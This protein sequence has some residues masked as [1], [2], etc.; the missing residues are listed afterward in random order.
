MF[1]IPF[2]ACIYHVVFLIVLSPLECPI[3]ESKAFEKFCYYDSHHN[4]FLSMK[5]FHNASQNLM[6]IFLIEKN[7]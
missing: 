5:S 6:M 4:T 3:P 1:S 7:K 2:I